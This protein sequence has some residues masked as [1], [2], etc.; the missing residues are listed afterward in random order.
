LTQVR[1]NHSL[2]TIL[3]AKGSR[4]AAER[5]FHGLETMNT[6]FLEQYSCYRFEYGFERISPKKSGKGYAIPFVQSIILDFLV[7]G[8]MTCNIKTLGI[9]CFSD[10]ARYLK[11]NRDLTGNKESF[12][13]F[14]SRK[15]ALHFNMLT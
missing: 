9:F 12:D 4:P 8:V 10:S 15:I 2:T 3:C 6:F 14:F 11:H 7:H 1:S 13:W 5:Y